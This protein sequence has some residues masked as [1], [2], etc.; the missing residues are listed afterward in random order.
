MVRTQVLIATPLEAELAAR[1]R[2]AEPRAEVLYEPDLL[3]P[4]RYPADHLATR[5]SGGTPAPNPA[6][7]PCSAGPR[8]CSA[9]PDDSAEG[10]VE[11]VRTSR[12]CG[13]S[14]P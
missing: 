2:E 8:C 7:G 12:G 4:A 5:P 1:I 13:G 11:A 6:G 9:S 10:L 14:M 3:P